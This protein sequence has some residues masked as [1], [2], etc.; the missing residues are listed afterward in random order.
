MCNCIPYNIPQYTVIDNY[1]YQAYLHTHTHSLCL[2]TNA[3]GETL[4][5][6]TQ[7]SSIHSSFLIFQTLSLPFSRVRS[8]FCC[9]FLYDPWLWPAPLLCPSPLQDISCFDFCHLHWTEDLQP[10]L[11]AQHLIVSGA[12]YPEGKRREAEEK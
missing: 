5:T 6:L 1:I 8:G 10:G 11:A 12:K 7:Q 3:L 4:S 9:P 2:S